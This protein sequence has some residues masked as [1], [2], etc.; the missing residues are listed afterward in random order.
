MR[1]EHFIGMIWPRGKEGLTGLHRYAVVG[2]LLTDRP[3]PEHDTPTFGPNQTMVE[4]RCFGLA[5]VLASIPQTQAPRRLGTAD[6][7]LTN[8][9]DL[10]RRPGI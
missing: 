4:G 6:S 5:D 1:L 7:V 9:G 10:I 3:I 2:L 8:L